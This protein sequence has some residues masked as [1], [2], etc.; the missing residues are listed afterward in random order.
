MLNYILSISGILYFLASF[1]L[2]PAV[3]VIHIKQTVSERHAEKNY[4]AKRLEEVLYIQKI[5]IIKWK[6]IL[7]FLNEAM[8][9]MIKQILNFIPCLIFE[10]SLNYL[11]SN[12][13][14]ALSST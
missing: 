1:L 2:L 9:S 4:Y 7:Q 3:F 5:K 8:I 14:K 11:K 6:F 10:F 13:L 12:I